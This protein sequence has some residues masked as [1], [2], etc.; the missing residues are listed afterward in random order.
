ML[1]ANR[2]YVPTA[3]GG[4]GDM[5]Y[6]VLSVEQHAEDYV[7]TLIDIVENEAPDRLEPQ[8]QRHE[9]AGRGTRCRSSIQAHMVM[10]ATVNASQPSTTMATPGATCGKAAPADSA[11]P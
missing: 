5:A 4:A 11:G 3:T 6:I 10:I 8:G 1:N 2:L 7:G 9:G